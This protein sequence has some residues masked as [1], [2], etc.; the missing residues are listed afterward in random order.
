MASRLVGDVPG[1]AAAVVSAPLMPVAKTARISKLPLRFEA[2]AGQWGPHVRFRARQGGASLFI[3]DDGMTIELRD[4][5][6]K[7]KSAAVTLKLVGAKPSGPYGEQEIVTKSNFFLGNDP[8][9]WRTNVPNYAVVRAKNWLTGVDIVWHGGPNG[10]EYDLDVAAGVDAREIAFD[11]EGAST[12]RVNADGALEIA[13]AAGTL[14][15]K[16]PHVVQSGRELVAGYRISGPHRITL[17]IHGYDPSRAVLVDPVFLTYS[18]YLGGTGGDVGIGIT[19]DS[20]GSAYVIGRTTGSF[21]TTGGAYQTSYGGGS[22][23]VFVAKLNAAGSALIYS[24]YLGG[25]SDDYGAAI[26]IDASGNAYVTGYTSGT[27]PTTLGAYQTTPG[28]GFDTFVTKLNTTGSALVYSTY[29]GGNTDDDGNCI[30]VDSNGN[31]YVTGITQGGFPTSNG[32]YQTTYGG[33][34]DA[35][36]STLNASGSA[37]VYSTYLG[38]SGDD[39][40]RGIA[41]DASGNAYVTGNT[42]GSFPTTPGAYQTAFGGTND[43]FITKL[44][45]GGS[46][47]TYSTYLGGIYGDQGLAIAVDSSGNAYV[48]G[49]TSGSFPTTT[50]AYQTTFGGAGD[51]F[52][53]KLNAAGSAVDYSTYLG[54][55]SIDQG[56][57]IAVDSSGNAYVTGYTLGNFPVTAGVFQTTY[58]GGNSDAFATKLN[59]MGSALSYSSYLGGSSVDIGGHIA[60]DSNDN[61]YVV[62]YTYGFP[63]TNGAYQTTFGGTEDAFIA[64]ISDPELANGT[65]CAQAAE[66]VSDLCV[67]GVCCNTTCSGQCEACDVTGHVGTCSPANGAPHGSRAACIGTSTACGFCDGTNTTACTYPGSTTNC[68]TSCSGGIETDSNCNGQ[69]ACVGTAHSCNNLVCTADGTKCKTTCTSDTDCLQGFAC[70]GGSCLPG[71]TCVNDHTAQPV[72]GPSQD[73]TPYECA[74]GCKQSCSSVDDCVAP[75]ICDPSGH[76]VPPVTSGNSGCSCDTSVRGSPRWA[77]ALLTFAMALLFARKRRRRS[78]A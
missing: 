47:L 36:V 72:S 61:A 49:N 28:G 73:C 54:G 32:A 22:Y 5:K 3:T 11:V 27:F 43:A 14:A 39:Y 46:A 30:A 66:C 21:P 9:K 19:V 4:M 12:L 71:A 63:T 48:T 33:G 23:D 6:Q 35:F 7:A 37:L 38:G 15:Q 41:L 62:G 53:T 18:T 78:V 20:S 65:P 56:S 52:V 26:T 77:G 40:G 45:V 1:N 13:T 42:Y 67:D 76:C 31:A 68:G 69:G 57:A 24:T 70:T 25:S 16:P 29:L 75:N 74:G 59:A 8:K 58:G 60:V 64:K 10:L 34:R 2:N 17:D 55:S 44:N 51:A 50:G